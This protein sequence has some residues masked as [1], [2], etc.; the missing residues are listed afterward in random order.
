MNLLR[1]WPKGFF[2][3][4]KRTR[5]IIK[6]FITHVIMDNVMTIAVVIN[7]IIM[8]LDR[9]GLSDEEIARND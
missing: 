1:V 2:G 7:T 4:I 8:T 6:K 3:V 5:F 9:Y